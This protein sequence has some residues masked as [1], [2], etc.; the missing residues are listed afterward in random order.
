[1][2]ALSLNEDAVMTHSA[3]L[4]PASSLQLRGASYGALIMGAFGAV[5]LFL[6]LRA[7]LGAERILGAAAVVACGL[8]VLFGVS[9]F[10]RSAPVRLSHMVDYSRLNRRF[11]L[12]NILQWVAIISWIAFLNV[13]QQVEWIVPGIMLIVGL[14]FLPLARLFAWPAH[15]ITGGALCLLALSYPF[16]TAQGPASPVGP[17]FAGLILWASALVTLFRASTQRG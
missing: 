16:L 4:S 15:Y 5:W 12:V 13:I 3:D 14:H 11:R 1:M 7:L 10:I 9:R 2:T 8:L 6:G 17:I